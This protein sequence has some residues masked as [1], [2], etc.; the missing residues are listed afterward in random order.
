MSPLLYQLSYT[1]K[2]SLHVPGPS[3]KRA[4]IPNTSRLSKICEGCTN[5]LLGCQAMR[6]PTNGSRRSWSCSTIVA[7]IRFVI[8]VRPAFL[9]F[10]N[11]PYTYTWSPFDS[12]GFPWTMT[13]TLP[14]AFLSRKV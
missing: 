11:M 7:S 13:V 6:H 3:I 4:R 14:S 8:V 1:A 2:Q 12:S 5:P 9:D 10:T